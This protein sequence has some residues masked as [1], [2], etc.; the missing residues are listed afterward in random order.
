M[1]Y[2]D[3]EEYTMGLKNDSEAEYGDWGIEWHLVWND[4][5]DVVEDVELSWPHIPDGNV[6]DAYRFAE[7]L[8]ASAF[9]AARLIGLYVA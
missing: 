5:G 7:A 3:F 6:T 2:A 8:A 1:R 9:A 4:E